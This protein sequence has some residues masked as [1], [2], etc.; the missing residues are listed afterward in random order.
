MSHISQNLT[1]VITLYICYKYDSACTTA[2]VPDQKNFPKISS[3]SPTQK[4][5]FGWLHFNLLF[6]LL[7]CHLYRSLNSKLTFL[8]HCTHSCVSMLLFMCVSESRVCIAVW[9]TIFPHYI[10]LNLRNIRIFFYVFEDLILRD[11]S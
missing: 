9:G 1:I 7:C 6:W 11:L 8:T 5:P 10:N 2:V 3:F 4:P